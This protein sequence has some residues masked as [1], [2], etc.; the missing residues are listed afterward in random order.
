MLGLNKKEYFGGSVSC[1]IES[2]G[3]S[4]IWRSV[5]CGAEGITGFGPVYIDSSLVLVTALFTVPRKVTFS[6]VVLWNQMKISKKWKN[7][8][9]A[10]L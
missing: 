9:V 5:I 4:V 1:L 3:N 8:I 2:G 7:Y 10:F 6:D